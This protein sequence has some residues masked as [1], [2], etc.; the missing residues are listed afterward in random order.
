MKVWVS[1]EGT[2]LYQHYEKDVSSKTVLNAKSAH[3]A[4]CKRGVHTQEVVRRLLN[5][6]HR[7]DWRTEI[8]PVI[9]EYM[10][11]MKAAGYGE[12]YRRD[13]LK[14]A[15][16]IFD[17]KWEDHRNGVQPIF[18]PKMW[19]KEERKIAKASKK[20]NWATQ[21]GYIAP[22]FYPYNTWRSALKDDER[23]C[24]GR[25]Q[26]RYSVQDHGSGRENAEENT[27][28]IQP[29]SYTRV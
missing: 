14:H 24:R 21:G 26:R 2:L 5:S 17:K 15:L 1:D 19:K 9:T 10:R 29:H 20:V 8:A 18:R 3:S 4:A 11:R 25:G 27:P 13:I 12:K 23:D 16:G 28:K 22:V 7:L 6:S